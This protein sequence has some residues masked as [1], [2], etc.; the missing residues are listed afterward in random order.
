MLHPI[1]IMHGIYVVVLLRRLYNLF[2]L[3]VNISVPIT[4]NN[5]DCLL[6][7]TFSCLLVRFTNEVLGHVAWLMAFG[8]TYSL[9]R[10]N[11]SL[12]ADC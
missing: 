8:L 7:L 3:I 10:G 9:D 11:L 1:S 12:L 2:M 5:P 6:L 4:L